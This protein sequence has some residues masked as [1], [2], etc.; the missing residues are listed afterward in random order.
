MIVPPMGP[1]SGERLLI[2]GL[3]S[4][5]EMVG[6]LCAEFTVTVTGPVVAPV[7]TAATICVALQLV[8]EVD[9]TPLK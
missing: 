2:T 8:T 3:M 7:G 9:A 1:Q 5:N 4:V 6:L